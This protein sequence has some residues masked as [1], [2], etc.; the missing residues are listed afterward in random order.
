MAGKER[1]FTIPEKLLRSGADG[2]PLR[3]N[4]DGREVKSMSIGTEKDNCGGNIGMSVVLVEIH[5]I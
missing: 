4:T 5:G 1:S 3:G 2:V